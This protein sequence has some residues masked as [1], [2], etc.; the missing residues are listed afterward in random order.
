METVRGL[1]RDPGCAAGLRPPSVAKQRSNV[2]AREP[3][4]PDAR[5]AAASRP[6]AGRGR[7]PWEAALSAA[8]RS[9][10]APAA[11]GP[12]TAHQRKAGL[13]RLEQGLPQSSPIREYPRAAE[14]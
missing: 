2:D 13:R 11:P 4:Q 3:D 8:R 9:G 1:G 12:D 6:A 10:E 14:A 7:R 5:I